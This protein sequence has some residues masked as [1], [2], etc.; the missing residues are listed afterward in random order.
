[1]KEP[2]LINTQ[3]KLCAVIGNPVSHSLSPLIHNAAFRYLDLNYVY[4]AFKVED[5]PGAVTG[6][7]S[8]DNMVGMSVTIPH[9]I[10]IIKELDELLGQDKLSLTL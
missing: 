4:L 5:I 2:F 10:N 9:K 6:M 8:L 3:T 1:M 7:R